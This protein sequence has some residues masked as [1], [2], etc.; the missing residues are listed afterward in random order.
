MHDT[1]EIMNGLVL[2]NSPAICL[3]GDS[4]SCITTYSCQ[5]S[6]FHMAEEWTVVLPV[7]CRSIHIIWSSWSRAITISS[8]TR[9]GWKGS[10][11]T[12]KLSICCMTASSVRAWWCTGGELERTRCELHIWNV[13]LKYYI[14]TLM[15]L[16]IN[17]CTVHSF[18]PDKCGTLCPILQIAIP[19]KPGHTST[20]LR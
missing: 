16:L 9:G 1:V 2:L 7:F 3:R 8:V 17:L 14:D 13:V 6:H 20:T 11:V 4:I 18:S 19:N 10:C 12:G 5:E 15:K